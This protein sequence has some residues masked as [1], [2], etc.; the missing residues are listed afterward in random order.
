MEALNKS[1]NL[2][3]LVDIL[4]DVTA[5]EQEITY[6]LY[7]TETDETSCKFFQIK[8]VPNATAE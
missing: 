8:D 3:I 1:P 5:T 2:S 4:T 7:L 6:I